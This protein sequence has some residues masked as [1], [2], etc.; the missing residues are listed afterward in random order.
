MPKPRPTRRRAIS[1]PAT[2]ATSRA[3]VFSFLKETKGVVSWRPEELANALKIS[4]AEARKILPVLEL[5]GYIQQKADERWITTASGEIVAGAKFPRFRRQSVEEAL[6]KFG[7]SLVENNRKGDSAYRVSKAVAFGDFLAQR[8]QV[9]AA[10]VGI[11]LEPRNSAEG[12]ANEKRLFLRALRPK[13]ALIHLQLYE[14]WMDKRTHLSL[15]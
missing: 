8:V 3:A 14:P 7:A 4:P 15:L 6:K 5:Q 10:D 11:E 9:Q 12:S 13:G 2:P 1:P